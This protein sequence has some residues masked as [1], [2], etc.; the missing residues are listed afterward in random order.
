MPRYGQVKKREILPDPV[1]GSVTV[2]KFINKI[3]IKGKKS[4][5]E[6]IFYESCEMIKQKLNKDPLEVFEGA[7]KNV[8]P[9]M[10]VKPRRVGG[11]TYQVPVEVPP[12]RGLAL[13]MRWIRDNARERPGKSMV[14]KLSAEIIDAYNGAGGA[15]KKREDTH[16]MAEANRAFAHFRW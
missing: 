5:S 8:T 10:A 4:L 7:I 11:S 6:S 1:F 15:A 13:A 3:M 9:L 16:K 12:E 14:E 2:Q